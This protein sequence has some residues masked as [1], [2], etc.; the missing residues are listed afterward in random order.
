MDEL[1][2]NNEN[3]ET[4]IFQNDE[5]IYGKKITPKPAPK[6]NIGIDVEGNFFDNIAEAGLSSQLDIA[7]IQSFTQVSQNRDT[8]MKLIDTMSE[9]PTIAAA[10]E[11]YAEDITEAND[12]GQ[13]IWCESADA[14]IANLLLIF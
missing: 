12:N 13:I 2:F 6:K 4:S 3:E 5:E 14:N 10:L 8:T 1:M 9:D 11:I 7:K